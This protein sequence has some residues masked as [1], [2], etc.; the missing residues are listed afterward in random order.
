M[1]EKKAQFGPSLVLDLRVLNVALD[2]QCLCCMP[3]H[4]IVKTSMTKQIPK[5]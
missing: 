4:C 5:Q 2:M 3:F 1:C